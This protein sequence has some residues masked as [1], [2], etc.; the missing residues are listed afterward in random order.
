M[1]DASFPAAAAPGGTFSAAIRL[2]N[3]GFAAP[4]N[5]RGLELVLRSQASSREYAL[6]LAIDPRR[7]GA[8]ETHDIAVAGCLP[9][10]IEPGVYDAFLN[11][12]DPAPRLRG[13]PEYSIRLANLGVWEPK[14][15]YNSLRVAV[16]VE[17]RATACSLPASFVARPRKAAI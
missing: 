9:A 12:P 8:G 13:R 3:D 2:T 5:A 6:Q 7:W 10:A 15:G 11:L 4:Y 16:R 17:G 1:I 14:T